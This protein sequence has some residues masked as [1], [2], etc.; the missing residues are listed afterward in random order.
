MDISYQQLSRVTELVE[1]F[2]T[3]WGPKKFIPEF[4]SANLKRK[5]IFGLKIK[6]RWL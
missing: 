4:Y 2:S 6:L 1:V 5:Y 3:K